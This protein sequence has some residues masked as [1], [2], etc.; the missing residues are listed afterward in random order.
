MQLIKR[1]GLAVFGCL[2]VSGTS[3]ANEFEAPPVQLASQVLQKAATG[4]GYRVRPDVR[5]DGFLRIYQLETAQG[6]EEVVGDG[7]L[8]LRL[9][10]LRALAALDSLKA[11]QSF[12]EGLKEAAKR[13][14]DFVKSAVQDPLGTTK[15]TVSGVGRLFGRIGQ[16]VENVVTG[17][18]GSPDELLKAVTGADRSRRELAVALNVDPYTTYAPLSDKLTETASVTTAGKWTVT[19]ITALIPG[20]IIA[21]AAGT[22]DSLRTMIIDST[23]TELEERAIG[24]LRNAGARS[25]DISAF[26]RNPNYT[27]SERVVFAYRLQAMT[28][29]QGRDLLVS[30]AAS[31]QTRDEAYFQLRKVVLSETYHRTIARFTGFRSV[32]GYPVAIRADGAAALVAPLDMVAWTEVTSSAFASV[33]K[34]MTSQ[35]FPPKSVDFLTTGSVTNLAAQNLASFGWAITAEYPMPEGPVH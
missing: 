6:V 20:G 15:S 31:A 34:G 21:Q 16:G 9:S 2:V 10:E 24:A 35:P 33:H 19:A 12:L 5:S 27:A 13:P 14:A 1:A 32:A 28:N 8:K 26:V 29:V 11:D 18:T 30:R 23:P 3:L 22:A 4:P 7:L 25:G 17:N